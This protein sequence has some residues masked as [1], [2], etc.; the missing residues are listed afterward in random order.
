VV[1]LIATLLLADESRFFEVIGLEREATTVIRESTRRTNI[2]YRVLGYERGKLEEALQK[3]V[4]EKT[5]EEEEGKVVIYYK[6]I[7]E[8]KQIAKVLG[9]EA[10]Y[11][12]VRTEEEKRRI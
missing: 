11:R 7:A 9:Y 8:T 2:V 6:T 3:L 5:R 12:E 4:E 1:F 10:Y